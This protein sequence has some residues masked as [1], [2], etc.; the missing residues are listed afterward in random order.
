VTAKK[1]IAI[2]LQI[3]ML[4]NQRYI[5]DRMHYKGKDINK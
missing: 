5:N 2:F 3:G 4:L 1:A